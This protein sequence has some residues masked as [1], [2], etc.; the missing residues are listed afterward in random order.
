MNQ[1]KPETRE[2]NLCNSKLVSSVTK[3]HLNERETI[4][5]GHRKIPSNVQIVETNTWIQQEQH[6]CIN[7]QTHTCTNVSSCLRMCNLLHSEQRGKIRGRR[8]RKEIQEREIEEG[9]EEEEEETK[10]NIKVKTS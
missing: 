9:E 6:T 10:F 4:I 5:Q 2:S 1:V 8:K 3:L 7:T